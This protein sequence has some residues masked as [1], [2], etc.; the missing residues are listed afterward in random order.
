MAA[1]IATF[2]QRKYESKQ[3]S[4][5]AWGAF[6]IGMACLIS[7]HVGTHGA[8]YGMPLV[9]CLVF[10]DPALG[11]SRRM[12]CSDT[13]TFLLGTLVSWLEQI[14]PACLPP[15]ACLHHDGTAT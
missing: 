12:G 1:G 6:S 15:W 8:A 9:L 13:T 10:G 14:A 11:E 2:G 4:A 5:F 3:V 7:P